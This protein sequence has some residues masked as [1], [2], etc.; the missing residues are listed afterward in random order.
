MSALLEQ[1]L[2]AGRQNPTRAFEAHQEFAVALLEGMR[3][4]D[5]HRLLGSLPS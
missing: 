2:F 1:R 4:G 5:I 3:R